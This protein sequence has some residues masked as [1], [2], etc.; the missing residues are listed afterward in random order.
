MLLAAQDEEGDRS[1]MTDLQ[2]RDEA[3]TI[4]LAGHETTAN[5]LT[6]TWYLLSEH[7]DIEAGL[8]HELDTVLDGRPPAVDDVPRL[9]YT[10]MVITEAMR[11]YPPAWI[12]GR[13]ALKDYPLASYTVPAGSIVI[14]SPYVM[15]HDV[16]YFPDPF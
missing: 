1:H 3:I 9:R 10:E 14:M 2:L 5:A 16:R 15:H 13:R 12:M 8:H 6:W 11:L 4:F 7:P